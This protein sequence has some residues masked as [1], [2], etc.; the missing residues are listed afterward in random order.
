[1]K[2]EAI[3]AAP[4]EEQENVLMFTESEDDSV[5][6]DDQEM[7]DNERRLVQVFWRTR[8]W[9]ILQN[10]AL[11][12][13]FMKQRESAA[14]IFTPISPEENVSASDRGTRWVSLQIKLENLLKNLHKGMNLIEGT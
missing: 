11:I 7:Q 1:M 3:A 10:Q 8:N 5:S 12:K 6:S 2:E 9:V 14:I 13:L 4:T